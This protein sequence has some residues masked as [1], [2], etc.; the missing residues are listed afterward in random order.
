MDP[1]S[2]VAHS[3]LELAPD[4]LET[5]QAATRI[6]AGVALRSLGVLAGAVTL[7]QF[8]ILAVLADSGRARSAQVAQ[9]LGIGTPTV[10]RFADS[11]AA[12]G[13]VSIRAEAG[14]RDAVVLEL[15]PSGE[16]LVGRVT[17]WREQ[18]MA[19]IFRQLPLAERTILIH[20]LRQLV[21]VAGEGYGTVPPPDARVAR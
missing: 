12:A 14:G 6:L 1:S 13:Y 2:E 9:A 3:D 7:P 10:T 11:M 19:R 5:L 16:A 18:E 8:R 17:A 20:A 21:E 4:A 15:S